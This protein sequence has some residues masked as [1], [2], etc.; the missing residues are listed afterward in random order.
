MDQCMC[1]GGRP[2]VQSRGFV[3]LNWHVLGQSNWTPY[4]KTQLQFC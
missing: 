3:D 1:L 2:L 4:A